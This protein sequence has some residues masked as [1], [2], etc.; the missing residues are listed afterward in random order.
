MTLPFNSTDVFVV[1]G[2]PAGLAAAIAARQQGFDVVVAD[3]A[4]ASIDKACGEG[5]M[6]DCLD[7]LRALD[8]SLTGYETGSFRGIKF[9]GPE[10]SAQADFPE[11]CG[12]GIRRL[13][14]HQV[15]KEHAEKIGVRTWWGVRVSG[16]R[17][18]AVLA[19]G[20]AI[21]SRWIVGADGLN[22][23][24][25]KW[26]GLS[27]GVNSG[28]RIGVRQHFNIQPWSDFVEVHWGNAGQ[29]YVTPIAENEVCVAI[30]SKR[31]FQSF[32][33]GLAHFPELSLRLDGARKISVVRGAVTMNRRLKLVTRGNVALMG[34]ASGSV[35]AITGDGLALAFRQA[36]ALGSAL[37]AKDLS[38]YQTAHRKIAQ[39]PHSMANAML[40]MDRSKWV[41]SR[42]LR[43]FATKPRLFE[44]ML[45]MHVG[46]RPLL[47]I[48]AGAFV[49]LG[50]NLLT[51]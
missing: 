8:V 24:V 25:R 50:W 13:L 21:R 17:E 16:I 22:S 42:V 9:V 12:I 33:V 43:V 2:G 44:Q 18:E 10:G 19:N 47:P 7:S 30:I 3:C 20:E 35:D 34:E 40:L 29:A 32:D 6:P 15:L 11:G 5:L 28:R 51:A 46:E 49:A 38:A 14:L 48:D 39:L 41:R 4:R 45:S 26:A 36:L 27:P 37:V 1:G 31:R 23:Q